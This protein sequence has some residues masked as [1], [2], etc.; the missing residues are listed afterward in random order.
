VFVGLC[1][2]VINDAGRE[3]PDPEEGDVEEFREALAEQLPK[4]FPQA[5]LS[6]FKRMVMAGGFIAG[7]MWYDA[8][9]K[10]AAEPA[11]ASGSVAHDAGTA[12]D[13]DEP[14]ILRTV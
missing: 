14:T 8:K 2:R 5:E 9:P 1:A 12:G 13:Q 10:A 6:P 3:P 11:K 7:G 4:W